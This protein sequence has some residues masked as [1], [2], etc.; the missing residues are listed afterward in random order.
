MNCYVVWSYLTAFWTTVVL[1]CL[2]PVNWKQCL[3]VQDWLFPAIADVIRAR[4]PY[5]SERRILQSLERSNGLVDP[6]TKPRSTAEP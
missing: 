5:A 4:E 2:Q 3:P 1:N 6:Q